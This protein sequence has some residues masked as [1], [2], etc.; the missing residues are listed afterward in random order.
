MQFDTGKRLSI[1]VPYRDR[2]AHLKKFLPH[3]LRYFQ[4]DKVDKAIAFDIT[5]F[6]LFPDAWTMVGSTVVIGATLYIA[7]RHARSARGRKAGSGPPA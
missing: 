3:M 6:G 2:P 1:V 7:G 5:L 4:R